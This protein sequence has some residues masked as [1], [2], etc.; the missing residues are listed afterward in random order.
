MSE[1]GDSQIDP[2]RGSKR[3]VGIIAIILIAVLFVL[4][5][6]DLV[7]FFEW[8]IA[9][10]FVWLVANYALRRIKKQQQTLQIFKFFTTISLV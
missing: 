3:A 6:L 1:R 10:F 4:L 8:I 7:S 2:T 5:F 9:A